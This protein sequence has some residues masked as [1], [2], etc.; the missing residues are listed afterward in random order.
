MTRGTERRPQVEASVEA[1]ARAAEAEQATSDLQ[2]AM[3]KDIASVLIALVS[4]VRVV[5][6]CLR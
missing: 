2:L 5:S 1:E 3:Q 6:L 4:S